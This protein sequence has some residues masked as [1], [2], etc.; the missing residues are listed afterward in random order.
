[1]SKK[2]IQGVGDKYLDKLGLTEKVAP[3]EDG[4]RTHPERDQF[5][6]WYFDAHL[7][8]G[9]TA[10]IVFYTK[11]ILNPKD[12]FKPQVS[13]TITSPEGKKWSRIIESDP[14]HFSAARDRCDVHI[15]GNHIHGDLE[16][17]T[18]HAEIPA[19]D[20]LSRLRADLTFHAKVP[21]WRPGAG[22]N[23]YGAEER[24]YF[25]WLPAIPFGTVQ[26]KLFYEGKEHRVSG[27][28]YHDHN[29]GN[30]ALPKVLSHWVWGR[31]SLGGFN[32]IFV[33]MIARRSYSSQKIPV[34][35]LIKG[36]KIL[37]GDGSFLRTQQTD[38][39]QHPQGRKYPRQVNFLWQRDEEKVELKLR[40]PKVIE[41]TSLLTQLPAWQRGIARLITNPY[42]FRFNASLELEINLK[43]LKAHE[44]GNALYELM[45]LR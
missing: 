25:S 43:H 4:L 27:E 24:Y 13:I 42:Y 26:G 35:L 38:F 31:A 36:R 1:M 28:G 8:D 17:Y 7:Q 29:W 18:L 9:S 40:E 41:A 23:Y 34:F 2:V 30:I 21:A 39:V 15:E 10:V 6:W 14:S 32:I 33:E 3:W 11:G 12:P 37:T 16:E 20:E 22:I 45:L 44:Q 19:E 5:E